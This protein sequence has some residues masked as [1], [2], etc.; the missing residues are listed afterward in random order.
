MS[1][2]LAARLDE[3]AELSDGRVPYRPIRHHFGITSFGVNVFTAHAPGD[4]VLNEHEEDDPD[5]QEELYFVIAGHATFEL[6]GASL[7]APAGTFVRVDPGVRRTAFARE[8]ETDVL[9]L[10]ATPGTAYA[11]S[12]WEV[13][14]PLA[15]LYN[16]GRYEEAAEQGRALLEGEPPYSELYYNVACC[17]ALAGQG[18]AAIAHV[19]RAIELHEPLRAYA[20]E[21]SDLAAIREEP[22]F[23]ELIR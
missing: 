6:D 7:D 1:G 15:P 14:G 16:A 3:I 21:D 11:P 13:W 17:E 9:A 4:R 8:A 22:A 19:R 5:E 12:G 2:Y 20:R 10:G 23:Q 18:A